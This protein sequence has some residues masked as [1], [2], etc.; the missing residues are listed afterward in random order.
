M[1]IS[2]ATMLEIPPFFEVDLTI[3]LPDGRY[4]IDHPDLV[5]IALITETVELKCHG[6]LRTGRYKFAIGT[7]VLE[8]IVKKRIPFDLEI[9]IPV[10][11]AT[12]IDI[13]DI[14]GKW[15]FPDHDTIAVTYKIAKN[16]AVRN[17]RLKDG[18]LKFTTNGVTLVPGDLPEHPNNVP[19]DLARCFNTVLKLKPQ[20][21][22]DLGSSRLA[23]D[24]GAIRI[25]D[26]IV[27]SDLDFDGRFD[28]SV[29][30]GPETA[31][32]ASGWKLG[33]DWTSAS[34]ILGIEK[35]G[36]LWSIRT[37]GRESV[38]RALS[39]QNLRAS[40]SEKSVSVKASFLLLNLTEILHVTN[41]QVEYNETH[42]NVWLQANQ[43]VAD[44]SSSDV[45]AHAVCSQAKSLTL[46]ASVADSQTS[47]NLVAHEEVTLKDLMLASG[48]NS[49]RD[50]ELTIKSM[51]LTCSFE[52]SQ[53]VLAVDSNIELQNGKLS[54][55]SDDY[56]VTAEI[57]D[58]M[59]FS[60]NAES[61]TNQSAVQ[62]LTSGLAKFGNVEVVG[63][64]DIS[65]STIELDGLRA[66]IAEPSSVAFNSAKVIPTLVSWRNGEEA[67]LSGCEI[68][69]NEPL[70]VSFTD[71]GPSVQSKISAR[72]SADNVVLAQSSRRLIF[73]DVGKGAEPTVLTLKPDGR[74]TV[75]RF[76]CVLDIEPDGS[77]PVRGLGLA[78]DALIL[79]PHLE[80]TY[81]ELTN[82]GVRIATAVINDVARNLT[83]SRIEK[84]PE[85]EKLGKLLY[86]FDQLTAE[87]NCHIRDLKET[88][89]IEV[90]ADNYFV[91]KLLPVGMLYCRSGAPEVARFSMKYQPYYP[92]WEITLR[93]AFQSEQYEPK[94][95]LRIER[96]LQKT[97]I[98]IE[99]RDFD[100][101]NV[102]YD[103]V[104]GWLIRPVFEDKL[105][106]RIGD[107]LNSLIPA[108][109]TPEEM[110][111]LLPEP[112]TDT[113]VK[114]LSTLRIQNA[115][116]NAQASSVTFRTSFRCL[117]S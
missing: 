116:F 31:L 115:G 15:A 105:N 9:T 64:T 11:G 106:E 77:P 17:I 95:G 49:I 27:D 70:L 5:K 71:L 108:V 26:L 76:G 8:L 110:L 66:S 14:E 78:A 100:C 101:N 16:W 59:T 20:G 93:F 12:E 41:T 80:G 3:E 62:L 89:R 61:N 6:V 35:R 23:I 90:P 82:L 87:G 39:I 21:I 113:L 75:D 19:F 25:T 53:P 104:F 1:S 83:P 46:S 103:E 114:V 36:P 73:T 7:D 94:S 10:N 79:T 38:P 81:V 47:L 30:L 4:P 99:E 117:I 67:R 74:L 91:V 69:L 13:K 44:V 72:V 52:S 92:E 40:D 102:M 48:G 88:L 2:E 68:R 60:L 56:S 45:T 109:L 96:D 29:A 86:F 111:R 54:A 97:R 22:L 24:N 65:I 33:A 43:L 98:K 50:A 34:L 84:P 107:T 58:V 18:I 51:N 28:L 85:G 37:V 63:D 112:K 57:R 42:A 32:E 55:T